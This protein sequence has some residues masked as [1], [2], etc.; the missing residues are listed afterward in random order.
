MPQSLP[1]AAYADTVTRE[2][3]VPPRDLVDWVRERIRDGTYTP[4]QRLVEIDITRATGA[5]RAKVR[6]AL[7]RLET[8]GLVLI[9]EFRGASVRKL[10][11]EEARQIYGARVALEGFAAGECARI[12]SD[13]LKN[14][15][16]G[17]QDA[18]DALET[19]GNHEAF[20]KIN[21]AW[22]SLIVDGS[23]NARIAQLLS[24][25]N[26]QIYRLLFATFYSAKRIDGA[27]ADHR[28]ITD[29][30]LRGDAGAA[31]GAMRAHINNGFLA[32]SEIDASYSS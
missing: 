26:I 31:E 10:G 23:G 27:N 11:L 16:Q 8:E 15:L 12:A 30:I 21:A 20:A 5:P 13:A 24:G 7:Q 28:V 22:H 18:M 6:E 17:L 2:T 1:T 32:L 29:A 19:T 25:L 9:E 3:V 4:G 14:R